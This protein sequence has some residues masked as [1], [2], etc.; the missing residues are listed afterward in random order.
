M[1]KTKK[2]KNCTN[3]KILWYVLSVVGV[4]SRLLGA[5]GILAIAIKIYPLKYQAKYF[6]ECVEETRSSGK[7]IATSVNFCNGAN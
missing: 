3:K 4:S 5:L 2:T 1:A 7:S 6:N